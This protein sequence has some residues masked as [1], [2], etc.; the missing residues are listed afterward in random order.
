MKNDDEPEHLIVR[1]LRAE[2]DVDV[3]EG[4]TEVGAQGVARRDY[5]Q[6]EAGRDRRA[7]LAAQGREGLA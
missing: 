1:T 4:Q 2:L 5:V 7:S 3:G 6:G